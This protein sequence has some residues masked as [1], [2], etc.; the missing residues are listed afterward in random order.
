METINKKPFKITY[1]VGLGLSIISFIFYLLTSHKRFSDFGFMSQ[2]FFANYIVAIAYLIILLIA[3]LSLKSPRPN[4][5]HGCWVNVVVLFS[6][7][8]FSLNKEMYVFA[9]FPAW[10]NIYTLA[11]IGFFLCLPFIDKFP[12]FLK[13]VI[14]V[15]CGA[16]FVLA[17]YMSLYVGILIPLTCIS[18]WFFGISLHTFVPMLWLWLIIDFLIRKGGRSKL[19]HF[20]WMGL[21]VP[22]LIL[23]FYLKKWDQIQTEIKDI[24]AQKNLQLT[25]DLPNEIL[26]AQKLPDDPMTEEILI[27]PFKSQGFWNNRML[28]LNGDGEHKFHDPLSAVATGLLGEVAI[29]QNTVET[30]LNIRKDYRHKTTRRSWTGSSLSTISIS[31]NIRVF[32]EYRMAYYEKTFIIH[33]ISDK[34]DR[35]F[36]FTANTQEALYTF[37]L[38]EGSIVTSLS[39]WINGKEEKSRLSTKQKADSAYT[40]I[41]GV[42]RRDPALVHWQEGNRVTVNV[43]PCTKEQDRTFK[44]GFTS[45]LLMDKGKIWLENIWF[46]GP[47]FNDAREATQISITGIPSAIFEL[48]GQFNKNAKGDYVYTGDYIPD[49]KIG[50]EPIPLSKNKFSFGGYDYHLE[51]IE[52][53]PRTC[54]IMEVFLDVTKKWTKEEYNDAITGFKDKEIFV[55]LP[56]KLKVTAENKEKIWE[57]VR[58]NQFSLPFLYNIINP[59]N[60]VIIT[61]TGHSSPLL[62]DIK[63]SAFAEKTTA[64]LLRTLH[65][66]KVINIG[67]ETSP[68]WRSMRE[69]SLIDYNKCN[70]KALIEQI[71]KN[72]FSAVFE[73]SMTVSLTDSRMRIVKVPGRNAGNA[74]DH[75][76]RVFAYNDVLRKIGKRYFEKE[77]YENELFREAEEGYVVTPVTSMI[78]LESQKDYEKMGIEQ[79]VNTVGNAGILGGGAVPEP[80]EWALIGLVFICIA[81]HLYLKYKSLILN[82]IKK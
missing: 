53:K 14:Y 13:A 16:S 78:V 34:E 79:N 60:A 56:E 25:N 69:L 50:F 58:E 57:E 20:T 73:D 42:E 15:L 81:R 65:K 9:P 30:L 59:E 11:M 2:T 37:H 62:E 66:I 41:V 45:P 40:T 7:S 31:N 1:L 55:W 77:K 49:W 44:I 39:L 38:P 75:L 22:L 54:K 82:F 4:I 47:D 23:G 10:L 33:N 5:S 72:T 6:I 28:N 70:L 26:L 24:L 48:P 80:H 32:P 36:W 43:F 21:V 3:K 76:L 8:A 64:Y 74:P 61:K 46:E 29:D 67:R 63:T 19:K 18:F 71:K 12:A 27:S 52:E 68:F 51:E 35:N 17:F